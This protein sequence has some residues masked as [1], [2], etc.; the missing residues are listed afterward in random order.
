MNETDLILI[1]KPVIFQ[2]LKVINK[3][4]IGSD[5]RMLLGKIKISTQLE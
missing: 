4:N 2:D 3:V 5:H 1:D